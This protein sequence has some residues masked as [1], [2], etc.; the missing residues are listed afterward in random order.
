M[1]APPVPTG[2]KRTG[3]L[4]RLECGCAYDEMRWIE[5]CAAHHAEREAFAA[6]VRAE[7]RG[8]PVPTTDPDP[9]S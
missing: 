4:V 8:E 6:R 5:E 2:L 1:S 7:H 9:W 3:R